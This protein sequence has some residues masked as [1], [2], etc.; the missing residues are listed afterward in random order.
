MK[1]STFSLWVLI[2]L[3]LLIMAFNPVAGS[4]VRKFFSAEKSAAPFQDIVIENVALKTRIAELENIV[5]SSTKQDSQILKAG[6]YSRYP[7]NIKNELLLDA[8]T[9]DGVKEG[10]PVVVLGG[11]NSRGLLVGRVE[12]AYETRSLIQTI[13]DERWQSAVRIGTR[14]VEALFKGGFEPRLTLIGK[15]SE[16]AG[17]EAVMN[18]DEKFPF[19]L[20]VASL[21]EVSISSDQAFKEASLEFPYTLNHLSILG[22]L[23]R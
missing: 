11:E 7:F 4:W 8:G 16:L 19:G 20:P 10:M 15:Q 6:V 22:I 14:G 3:I 9:E 23:L 13:F 17:G 1:R 12:K 2:A 21:K 5:G 18:A